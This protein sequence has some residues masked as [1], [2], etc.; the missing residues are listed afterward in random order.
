MAHPIPTYAQ[1]HGTLAPGQTISVNKYTVQVERY[2]SQGGFAHV[3]LV[4]TSAPVYGTTHHVLKRIAVANDSMLTDVK[5]EVDIMRILKGHPNIVHLID[6]AWHRLSNGTYEVFILMEFCPGGGIIDMMNRR[7]RERLTEAEI[8]TIFVDVCEGVAA[9]HNLKPAL[10]H[11]D[12]K[13]ENILQASA[14]SFKLC[15]FGSATIVNPKPPSTTQE[16]RALEADLNRHTTLQYRAPEMVDPFMRRPVDEKSDVWALGV[17]LYKLCYYTTPFEEHGPLAILNVQYK[18]PPYPVYSSH[19]IA[20]IA[21]MLREHGAQRPAIFEILNNVHRLRGTKSRFTYTISEQAPLSPRST[22]FGG[23]KAMLDDLV[24]Y[25]PQSPVSTTTKNNGIQAREKVFEAIAPMRRG[26]PGA[27]PAPRSRSTS[28]R[29]EPTKSGISATVPGPVLSIDKDQAWKLTPKDNAF[30]RGHKSGLVTSGAWKV[31]PST[32]PD[33]SSKGRDTTTLSPG[34][35]NDFFTN[36]FGDSFGGSS[37]ALDFSNDRSKAAPIPIPKPQ[38]SGVLPTSQEPPRVGTSRSYKAKDAFEGLGLAEKPPAPTLAEARM[39]RTG[40]A[41]PLE[42]SFTPRRLSPKPQSSPQPQPIPI[43]PQPVSEN[44]PAEERFPSI[45]D[46]DRISGPKPSYSIG[47]SQSSLSKGTCGK[48]KPPTDTP[49]GLG[50]RP[51]TVTDAFKHDGKD[52]VSGEI[53]S[54]QITGRLQSTRPPLAR[55][56]T[57]TST[58]S[59]SNPKE[60]T[61]SLANLLSRPSAAGTSSPSRDWLTGDDQENIL[62]RFNTSVGVMPGADGTPGEPVLR[63]SPSKRASFIE[64]NPHLIVQPLEGNVEQVILPET[65]LP[66]T[67]N[68]STSTATHPIKFVNNRGV[69][70]PEING[71]VTAKG[72]GLSDNW[73]PLSPVMPKGQLPRKPS[74]G[75]VSSDDGPED[76][77]GGF[78]TLKELKRSGQ[79][80]ADISSKPKRRQSSVHDLVDLWGGSNLLDKDRDKRNRPEPEISRSSF[81]PSGPDTSAGVAGLPRSSS[82]AHQSLQSSISDRIPASSRLISP[83]V[84]PE[85]KPTS[86]TVAPRMVNPTL[87]PSPSSNTQPQPRSRPQSMLIFPSSKSVGGEAG[88]SPSLAVPLDREGIRTISR[89]RRTSIT[90]MVQ[91]YEGIGGPGTKSPSL[92]GMPVLSPSVPPKPNEGQNIGSS[93]TRFI[94]VSPTNSPVIRQGLSL[95]VPEDDKIGLPRSRTSPTHKTSP[96]R[97]PI[98]PGRSSSSQLTQ[99]LS[100]GE[101]ASEPK[102][103]SPERQYAGVS[104]LIDQWQK[105]AE[106]SNSPNARK[107]GGIGAKRFGVGVGGGR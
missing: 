49:T 79:K 25:K 57:T 64:K 33:P 87:R 61:D 99:Q 31:K 48:L 97:S 21:S 9:M 14:T 68:S 59:F 46:L 39:A 70:L 67:L 84:D 93:H 3:Y 52:G 104:K 29:K 98:E 41:L 51:Q 106:E 19:M 44:A 74:V 35:D 54:S 102:S 42:Q 28:P 18:I 6:A 86:S 8:L 95:N 88:L 103:P 85:R 71:D 11:R 50:S 77:D 27:S 45:E 56:Y 24:T 4:R 23:T 60:A 78:G 73:S 58:T 81:F 91:R 72:S 83:V 38:L 22:N 100:P 7:L 26:R 13:V 34:F 53:S 107:P 76:P 105:K 63:E 94:K 43:L 40:L 66:S 62:S 10:L 1:P 20:L 101:D 90:D 15:D 17:L 37:L 92:P 75:S 82:P 96:R 65:A 47:L 69:H 32:S 80:R 16:I 55:G 12:L 5:K 36:G 30:V 2:L 89:S